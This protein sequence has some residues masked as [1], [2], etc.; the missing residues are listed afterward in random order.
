MLRPG[1]AGSVDVGGCVPGLNEREGIG[2]V[3]F[4]HTSANGVDRCFECFVDAVTEYAIFMLDADGAV[5]SWNSGARRL[6]GYEDHE[7][8]GEQ[9]SRFHLAS[10]AEAMRPEAELAEAVVA[11]VCRTDG[12]RVRK[13]GTSFW[14]HVVITALFDDD[15]QLT[16]YA[17][18]TRDETERRIVEASTRT[19]TEQARRVTAATDDFL[20]RMS[21]EL[22]TPL[23]AI[24]GFGQVLNLD[25][26]SPTQRECVDR[27]VMAG[28]H[29]LDLV[30]EVLG[31]TTLRSGAMRLSLASVHVSS[32]VADAVYMMRPLADRRGVSVMVEP[33]PNDP[34]VRAD[35][36]RLHQVLV[37]L[38]ENAIKHNPDD[39]EVRV[40]C[41]PVEGGRVRL[42]VVDAGLGLTES[43]LGRLF[44]PFERLSAARSQVAGKGLGLAL[45]KH[46]V[47]AMDGSV[48]VSSRVGEGCSFWIDLPVTAPIA[49]ADARLARPPITAEPAREARRVLYVEDNMSNVRLVERVLARHP[50]ALLTVATTGGAA[51]ERVFDDDDQPDVIFLDLHLPDMSGEDVLARVR[52][53][54][55][56]ANIPVVVLTADATSERSD[57]LFALGANAYLTKP[58]DIYQLLDIIDDPTD[59]HHVTTRPADLP[60]LSEPAADPAAVP[61]L[62][63]TEMWSSTTDVAHSMNLLVGVI[64]YLFALLTRSASDRAGIAY[65]AEVRTAT[66]QAVDLVTQMPSRG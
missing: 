1:V 6:Y 50:L 53:D 41:A 34:Y 11:G 32:A 51:L 49:E 30:D 29:L 10:D 39:G 24:L 52:A 64:L 61:P 16:G 12:W 60:A 42:T 44:E 13:D 43:D 20:S 4:E 37:N 66:E 14:A 19:T 48:G 65:L 26:L 59:Q 40:R 9:L 27:I 62:T 23:N 21:H 15:R 63:D 8:L 22:L 57:R 45:T 31:L 18:V 46:L 58:F 3:S 55:R 5:A 28:D 2:P 36:R 25:D 56:T 38:L 7:A 47:E 35:R 54:P 33:M 17:H